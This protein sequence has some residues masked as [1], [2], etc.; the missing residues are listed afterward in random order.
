MG[1]TSL[2]DDEGDYQDGLAF[3]EEKSLTATSDVYL[4]K[5][6]AAGENVFNRSFI[7]Q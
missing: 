1:D 6:T 2:T 4:Q 5:A 7:K 3:P